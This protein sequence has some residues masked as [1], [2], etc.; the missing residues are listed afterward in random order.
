LKHF[1][2]KN[3]FYILSGEYISLAKY[4]NGRVIIFPTGA[5]L[6]SYP[7]PDLDETLENNFLK[8]ILRRI[9]AINQ[10]NG[11]KS[12]DLLTFLPFA[13][14]ENAIRKILGS[15]RSKRSKVAFPLIIS[16][17]KFRKIS[18]VDRSSVD[19]KLAN[20]NFIVFSPSRLVT[21]Q[22]DS[23][24]QQGLWKNSAAL[25]LGFSK[26]IAELSPIDRT[27]VKLVLIDRIYSPDIGLIKEEIEKYNLG[28]WVLWLKGSSSR[29]FTRS[30][31]QG[32]YSISSVV[33][34]DF[35]V[36]WFGGTALEGLAFELPVITH[37][38]ARVMQDIYG[39][40]PFLEAKTP[41]EIAK[42]LLDLYRNSNLAKEI[43][44]NGHQWL[45]KNYSKEQI[46]FLLD[47]L[48]AECA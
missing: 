11:V 28:D 46:E 37:T 19:E 40:N 3:D 1:I 17:G 21:I 4:L 34:D 22:S 32:I 13:P 18:N 45:L 26:F 30:E 43:G 42:K 36:G 27:N 6:T 47:Q 5:D 12:A 33:A 25:I 35:G 23:R 38:D 10:R 16:P 8:K 44:Q 14:Y 48:L 31:L 24:V 20:V 9:F 29:G 15:E 7:F 39:E 2:G 41:E